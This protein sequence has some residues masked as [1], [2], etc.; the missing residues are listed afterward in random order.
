MSDLRGCPW[1]SGSYGIAILS[2]E[3]GCIILSFD[4]PNVFDSIYYCN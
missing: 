2:F 4:G 3:R 1:Q